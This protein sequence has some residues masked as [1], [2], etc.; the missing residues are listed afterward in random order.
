MQIWKKALAIGLGAPFI[1]ALFVMSFLW[2]YAKMEP[3]DVDVAVVGED[4][5]V[6]QMEDQLNEKKPGLF[7]FHEM[8]SRDDA[9]QAIKSRDAYGAIV[10]GD[11]PEVLTASAASSA[12][13]NMMTGV[14][15]G[16]QQAANQK[17]HA[18]AEAKGVPADKVPDVEVPVTDVVPL[19][20]TDP[21]GMAM[22]MVVAPLAIG[23]MIGAAMNSFI[24]HRKAYRLLSLAI[25]CP[26][27]GLLATT[28]LDPIL[29]LVD[30]HFWA[31]WGV[32]TMVFAALTTTISG[33][34][35]LLG[36]PG[37]ALGVVLVM[38]IGTPLAA[39]A[40]PPQ[41]LPGW[42]GALGQH[43]PNGAGAWLIRSVNYF[44][45]AST[46][47]HWWT[48]IGWLVF[49][50]VLYA[51]A[52]WKDHGKGRHETAAAAGTAQPAAA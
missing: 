9:E 46:A 35:S 2:P 42:S 21:N 13:H 4:Q 37:F 14:A 39:P 10:L 18:A 47:S 49:G 16:V 7:T 25:Y 30:G 48:L 15:D 44:P 38:L 17:A 5:A 1:V 51:L 8:D 6:H 33:L 43:I 28:V 12:T 40:F 19:S 3:R 45:E 11:K 27:A 50:L 41:F 26:L 31:T 36:A 20:S 34:K 52:A 29:G 22:T 23:S 24:Q 32:F